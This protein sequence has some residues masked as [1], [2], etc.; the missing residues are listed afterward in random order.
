MRGIT[1]DS[2]RALWRQ[3][4][5]SFHGP[6]VETGTIPEANLLPLLRKFMEISHDFYVLQEAAREFCIRVENGEV[7][8]TYTYSKFK[9]LLDGT[10]DL[11]E[12]AK[13]TVRAC[14]HSF[15]PIGDDAYCVLC[16]VPLL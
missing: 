14:P 15:A 2:L 10:C 7:K 6:N 8:S 3:S 13:G 1:D 16:G 9:K 12:R 5:G 11:K 4:G